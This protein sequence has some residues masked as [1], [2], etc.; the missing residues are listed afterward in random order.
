M[1]TSS[2]SSL[3]STTT[4]QLVKRPSPEELIKNNDMIEEYDSETEAIIS[5]FADF[6]KSTQSPLN[7]DFTFLNL[8]F[9]LKLGQFIWYE[10][11]CLDRE[12][13]L[14]EKLTLSETRPD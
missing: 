3:S 12:A 9:M 1:D 5:K 8:D 14:I 7:P 6:A 2:S 11:Q 4:T 10:I 13:K